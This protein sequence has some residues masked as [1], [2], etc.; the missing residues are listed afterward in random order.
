MNT[1]RNFDEGWKP[2]LRRRVR[3]P[4]PYDGG[5][6]NRVAGRNRRSLGLK[7]YESSRLL[8]HDGFLARMF[9]GSPEWAST[10]VYLTWKLSATKQRRLLFRLVPSAPR[11]GGIGSGLLP[12]P[13]GAAE[14]PNLG[15]NKVNGP[16]SLIEAARLWPTPQ[17]QGLK[18]CVD[19]KTRPLKMGSM[20]FATPNAADAIGSHGGGQNR[21]L[22]T[23]VGGQ[24]N[25]EFVE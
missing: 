23:D 14:A 9:L 11:I 20:P 2:L 6:G 12:T 4:W 13:T 1:R 17:T 18:E 8:G 5:D 3:R 7:C 16:K 10:N 21:S 25:P 22:R 24:L 19:V 15:S